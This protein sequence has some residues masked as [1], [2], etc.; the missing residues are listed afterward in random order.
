M[1][2]ERRRRG[3][4]PADVVQRARRDGERAAAAGQ[5]DEWSFGQEQYVAYLTMLEALETQAIARERERVAGELQGLADRR[6]DQRIDRLAARAEADAAQDI[7]RQRMADHQVALAASRERLNLLTGVPDVLPPGTE[8]GDDFVGPWN[9]REIGPQPGPPNPRWIGPADGT[10]APPVPRLLK[11][12]LVALLAVVEVPIYVLTFRPFHPNDIALT[13]C[14]TIAVAL[15]MV[16]GPHLSGVWLRHRLA[17]PRLGWVTAAGSAAAL[18]VW[19]GATVLLGLLRAASLSVT[20][21]TP[22]GVTATNAASELGRPTL[23]AV[24]A[25]LIALSGLISFMLGLAEN[26][27]GVTALR[28]AA[29]TARD[30]EEAYLATVSRHAAAGLA[31]S[32]PTDD[33]ADTARTQSSA[34]EAAIGAEYRAARA[35]YLDAVSLA[36]GRPTLSDATGR[37]AAA[38]PTTL[39]GRSG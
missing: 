39:P 17:T 38:P 3:S 35:A 33:T 34:R 32:E 13:W 19:A 18:L 30:A 14:F 29:A 22:E 2:A 21:T 37:A 25:L 6:Q 11:I 36:V 15:V 31:V 26:H 9:D 20:V 27:P 23:T 4:E 16:L 28:R 12:I 8:V 1:R 24:F 5:Y 7:A 10:L